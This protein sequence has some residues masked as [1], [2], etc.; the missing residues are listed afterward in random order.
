[1]IFDQMLQQ[2]LDEKKRVIDELE[3]VQKVI[4]SLEDLKSIQEGRGIPVFN[5]NGPS[6]DRIGQ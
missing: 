5:L 2:L 4:D 6:E 3:K 1:M